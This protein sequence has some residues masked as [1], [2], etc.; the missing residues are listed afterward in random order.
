MEL[1]NYLKSKFIGEKS[2]SNKKITPNLGESI[3]CK[4][5][6]K[7]GYVILE[8]NFRSRFGEIDIIAKDYEA[9]CF[10][11]VKSRMNTSFGFPEEYVDNRK[12]KKLFKTSQIYLT[13]KLIPDIDRRFDVISVDLKNGDCRK[14]KNAFDVDS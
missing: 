8:K 7:N 4:Y 9:L 11:E 5:L 10:I 13:E 3:A 12:Q 6:K 1:I 2:T 14:V